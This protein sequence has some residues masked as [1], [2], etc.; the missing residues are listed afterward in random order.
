MRAQIER[1]SASF[2]AL[3]RQYSE[4]GSAAQGGDLGWVNPGA[5]VPEFEQAMNRLPV[6]G[7][8]QP[9]SSRFGVHLIEVVERRETTLDAKQLREQARI[10]LREQKFEEAYLEWAKELR[11]RAYVEMRD[12]P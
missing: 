3:A 10:A 7:L 11:A 6:G 9:V 2:E 5:F 8:S 4:D 12:P 1:G